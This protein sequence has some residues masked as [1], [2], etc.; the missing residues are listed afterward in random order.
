MIGR[1]YRFV[2]ILLLASMA[3]SF[4][5]DLVGLQARQPALDPNLT[6]LDLAAE[7]ARRVETSR[8]DKAR[9]DALLQVMDAV[10][11]GVYTA[12]GAEVVRGAERGW[13]DFYLYDFEVEALANNLERG[14]RYDLNEVTAILETLGWQVEDRYPTAEDLLSALRLTILDS[15]ESPADPYSLVPLLIHMIGL[16]REDDPYDLSQDLT[17]EQVELNGLQ[18]LLLVGDILLPFVYDIEPIEG[19]IDLG[20]QGGAAHRASPRSLQSTGCTPLDRLI[21]KAPYWGKTGIR[22]AN[23][24]AGVLSKVRPAFKVGGTVLAPIVAGFTVIEAIHGVMLAIGI[25]VKEVQ[26]SV[27]PTHYGHGSTG[28]ALEFGIRVI[29][30]ADFGEVR[31]RCG[32]LSTVKFP[33]K[34]PVSGVDVVW[35]VNKLEEHGTLDCKKGLV[36]SCY[37][38]TGADGVARLTFTPKDEIKPYGQGLEQEEIGLVSGLAQYLTSH[39]NA[40][41]GKISEHITPLTGSIRWSVRFHKPQAYRATGYLSGIYC[42]STVSTLT[43]AAGEKVTLHPGQWPSGS[44]SYSFSGGC[45]ISGEGSY[46]VSMKDDGIN[47]TLTVDIAGTT[48][49]PGLGSFNIPGGGPIQITLDPNASCGE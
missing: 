1:G 20:M 18:M 47:G 46:V 29:N 19:P 27:G 22:A 36:F 13:G 40:F 41:I 37:S 2:I 7:L 43:S 23:T 44:A 39:G 30:H 16:M 31:V 4:A 10:H 35:S 42:P 5:N 11:I 28:K 15:R 3:C 45:N 49:C 33:P 25:E 9:Y 48:S 38:T 8:S 14:H 17:I 6:G 34:G 12:E 21:S 24:L 26:P 32:W